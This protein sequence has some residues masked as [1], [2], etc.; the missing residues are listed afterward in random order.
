[1][2]NTE[3]YIRPKLGAE[4]DEDG[5]G[6]TGAVEKLQEYYAED[7]PVMT[8]RFIKIVNIVYGYA[9]GTNS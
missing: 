6:K 9:N 7:Y 3:S 5:L 2:D 1:M 4:K 8:P